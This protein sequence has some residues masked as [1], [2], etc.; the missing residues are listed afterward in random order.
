MLDVHPPPNPPPTWRDFLIHIATIVVGLIIAVG[1]E[2]LVERI[3]LHYELTETREALQH[4]LESN[5]ANI[6]TDERNWLM[7]TAALKNNLLVL[8]FIRSH[9]GT[10]QTALPGVLSGS[11]SPFLYD[12]AVWDA[13]QKNGITA[14]MP[15]AESNRDAELYKVFAAL[16]DQSLATWNAIN[17]AGRFD[18]L[19]TDPTHL[20]PQ[21]LEQTIQFTETALEM[22]IEMGYTFG[23]LAHEFPD[24]PQLITWKNIRALRPSANQ[25]DPKGLAAAVQ[26]TKNRIQAATANLP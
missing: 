24:M 10:P 13:A 18:L 9:P 25:F 16:D 8:E 23:R 11:Q 15:L 6:V 14:H 7:T 3:H 26:L 12:H 21:Q 2:Q 4:E 20:S 22:H 17:D 5:H 1:L 19:D